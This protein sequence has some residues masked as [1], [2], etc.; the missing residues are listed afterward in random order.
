[1]SSQDIQT[2]NLGY[3]RIGE[4]RELK[5]VVEAFWQGRA[6]ENQLATEASRLRALHWKKQ[7]D[8]GIDL[9]PSNDFSYYDHVLDTIALLGAVPARFGWDGSIVDRTTYFKMA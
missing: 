2:Q 9:I 7:R 6:D 5:R 8:A 3:P 4:K 1:M